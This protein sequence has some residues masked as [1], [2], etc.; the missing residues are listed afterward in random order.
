MR[1]VSGGVLRGTFTALVVAMMGACGGDTTSGVGAG[2]AGDARD[3]PGQCLG[4]DALRNPY[5]GDLHVHTT[6]SLDA[7]TQGTRLTPHDAYRY[8]RGEPLGIQPYDADGNALRTSQLARPL[9]FAAVTDHAELFGEVD[10]CTDPELAGY[11][12]VE[13]RYYRRNPQSAFTLFNL[14]AVGLPDLSRLPIS[15]LPLITR[16][17][18]IGADGTVP[19]MPFCGLGGERCL[20]A[21]K[22]P[23]R[24]TQAAAEA[25]YD[26][27][28]D[29]AFTTFVGYEWTG[30]PLSN[31]LHRNV[32]FR[33]AAVPEQ[34]PAYQE[35][36]EPELLW[37]ALDERCRDE[38]GCD[39]LTIPHNSNLSAGL[40]FETVDKDGNAYTAE[41]AAERRRNEPLAEIYQHKGSSECLNTAGAGMQDELCGFE[42]LPYNN[43][44]GDRF[45]GF[46]T[47]PPVPQ[48]FLREALKEGLAQEAA[49]GEN[50]FRY[51]FIASS[52]THLATPGLVAEDGFPGHGGAG[53]PAIDTLPAG[54]TDLVEYSPGGLAVIW[55]EENTREALFAAMERRE[56][57]GTSGNR[58]VV[59]FFGGWDLPD[60]QCGSGD[61]AG[62]GYDR[63]V[64]MG[65]MLPGP[66]ADA[67]APA[68]AVAATRDP[69]SG[70]E[71]LQR[72]QIVKGWIAGGEKHEA[73]YE[74]AGDPTNG[75]GVD[76]QTCETR[77]S[78]FAQLCSVWRDP[79]F[80][81]Q[82]RAFYYARVVE[83]PSCR[84]SH[85][86]CVAA[87]IDC[88]DPDGVPDAYAG[89]C[90]ASIPDTIQERAWTSPIWYR[91]E[92]S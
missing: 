36:P 45:G 6:Y 91:P 18:L 44:T 67:G 8:A 19:R 60:N 47:G 27:S 20:E 46:N 80:D 83:N 78:G 76:L 39:F 61:F 89:C 25:F 58:P 21:A 37:A 54:L 43:L 62:I 86:Q 16:L 13:C 70:A 49:I 38:D 1:L 77:G 57:Y 65:A 3:G 75:A 85:R 53:M 79:D 22:T 63:G 90:D 35:F 10:I 40:M 71:P 7:N 68:F 15:D 31:N 32:L 29:C 5:F 59:R 48:D 81:P 9:D 92:P 41:V 84:W 42:I 51:G 73:V 33:S 88:A 23:W 87:G 55:A 69:A 52:D 17:P 30:A 4:F 28:R 2:G 26:R 64:P 14:F 72:I 12:S 34:P 11:D 50:P 66:P 56:V 24:D 74:V 82:Q